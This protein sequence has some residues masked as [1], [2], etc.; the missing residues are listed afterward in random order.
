LS[1]HLF[2]ARRWWIWAAVLLALVVGVYAYDRPAAG[3]AEHGAAT[4]KTDGGRGAGRGASAAVPVQVAKAITADVPVYLTALGTVTALQTVA[5]HTRVD[6]QLIRVSFKEGQLVH[7][8]DLLAEIDPRP[9]QVQLTQAQGQL[10]RDEAALKNAQLDLERYQ[11]LFAQDAV[12]KQQLDTQAAAV[13]QAQGTIVS[14]RGQVAAADLNVTYAHVTSPIT[15]RVGLRLVDPGNIVHASDQNGIVMITE[16][17]P[18][19]VVFTIPEDNLPAV[20]ERQRQSQTLSVAAYDRDMT[21]KLAD[22][23]LSSIDSQIDT[24]T[25]TIKLKA[26]F[27]NQG[28]PLFPNQFVNARLLINTIKNAVVVPSVAI[29]RGPQDSFVYVVKADNTV[30]TRTVDVQLAEADRSA[31]KSGLAAGE[32]VVTDGL[33][34]LQ[35][36][37]KVAVRESAPA[38]TSAP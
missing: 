25:G 3:Q 34:K 21:T 22:G 29:Q 7:A 2:S 27:A 36:G 28:E 35:P 19:A 10:A 6:G 18:I 26:V 11:A 1:D 32:T 38:G 13:S 31:I 5:V 17:Q 14:D 20:L 23:S 9:F 16:R 4:A 24:S 12:A 8:G 30:E 33:D 15:G 37:S